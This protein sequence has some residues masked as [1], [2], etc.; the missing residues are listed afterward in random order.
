MRG[1]ELWSI[2]PFALDAQ[3]GGLRR[4]ASEQDCSGLSLTCLVSFSELYMLGTQH[5]QG[6]L[7]E[8][9]VHTVCKPKTTVR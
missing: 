6:D 2:L 7:P 1:P 8:N 5:A 4:K 9:T 3:I